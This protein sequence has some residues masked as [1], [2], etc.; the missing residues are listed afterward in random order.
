MEKIIA[1]FVGK[2]VPSL[3]RALVTMLGTLLLASGLFDPAGVPLDPALADAAGQVEAVTPDQVKDGLTVGETVQ[4]V[5]GILLLWASRL[6]SF[7]RAKNLD[8]VAKALGWLIGRSV[9]SLI[10]AGLTS[11]SALL[12][13]LTAT[14]DVAPD[15]IANHPLSSIAA[16]VLTFGLGRVMSAIEDGKRNP[17]K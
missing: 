14:P 7:L 1:F 6:N 10:R 11:C 15:V 17:V 8:G 4:V 3:A 12:A 16:A 9:P 13:Y 2:N 5:M